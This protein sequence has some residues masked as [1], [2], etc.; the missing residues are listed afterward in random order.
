MPF[1]FRWTVNFINISILVSFTWYERELCHWSRFYPC[2]M[3]QI[4]LPIVI[5][6]HPISTRNQ[7]NIV[8]SGEQCSLV[9]LWSFPQRTKKLCPSACPGVWY[10]LFLFGS[11]FSD[12]DILIMFFEILCYFSGWDTKCLWYLFYIFNNNIGTKHHYNIICPHYKVSFTPNTRARHPIA[13][14]GGQDVECV[15]A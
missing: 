14:P 15:P 9:I 5:I 6:A 11:K 3:E 13:H 7:C 10:G 2:H 12:R 4:I 1:Q 8:L